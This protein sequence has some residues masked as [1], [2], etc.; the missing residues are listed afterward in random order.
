MIFIF[1][2]RE[3][4][5]VCGFDDQRFAW[6]HQGTHKG[7]TDWAIRGGTSFMRFLWLDWGEGRDFWL[8]T[9]HVFGLTVV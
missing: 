8:D 4:G 9:L 1:E 2:F 3:F 7:C 6:I 5:G